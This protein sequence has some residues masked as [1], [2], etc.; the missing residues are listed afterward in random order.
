MIDCACA[1][2]P[3]CL[4]TVKEAGSTDFPDWSFDG[5]ST[6]QAEGNDSDCILKPVFSCPDPIRGSPHVLVV[7]EVRGRKR[8]KGHCAKSTRASI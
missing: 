8:S 3:Q 6:G 7:C 4:T 5:S 2:C 1:F